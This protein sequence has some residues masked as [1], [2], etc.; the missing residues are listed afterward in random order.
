M[1]FI[2]KLIHKAV[3]HVHVILID[4][5]E[6]VVEPCDRRRIPP[7]PVYDT[8]FFHRVSPPFGGRPATILILRL[9]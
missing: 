2:R 8:D 7:V 5:F 9:L 6:A 1:L 3:L 4:P